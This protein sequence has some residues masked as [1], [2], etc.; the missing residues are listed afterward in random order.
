M[1]AANATGPI[2]AFSFHH[3]AAYV[4][5]PVNRIAGLVVQHAEFCVQDLHDVD[6]E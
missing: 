1:I 4:L 2:A 6:D 5:F 3:F